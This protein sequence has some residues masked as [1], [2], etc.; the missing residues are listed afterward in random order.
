MFLIR[1]DFHG[2][3]VGL[4]MWT[5]KVGWVSSF[6][7]S[8]KMP[9]GTFRLL[10]LYISGGSSTSVMERGC[11]NKEVRVLG[12]FETSFFCSVN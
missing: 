6:F 9:T 4:I 2:F 12:Y 10:C 8:Q 1:K 11:E 7:A 3:E 5:E